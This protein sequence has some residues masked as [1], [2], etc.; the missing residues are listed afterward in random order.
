MEWT[1]GDTERLAI[2]CAKRGDASALH[3][4]YVRYADDVYR[5]V[6]SIVRDRHE[7][8]DVSQGVFA[9]LPTAID[10]YDDRD[11]PLAA[12]IVRLARGVALDHMRSRSEIPFEQVRIPDER[13]ERVGIERSRSLRTALERLPEE[14]R[15][16][17][18]RRHIGR[19]SPSEIAKSLGKSEGAV[20]G[21]YHSGRKALRR[22]LI[23]SGRVG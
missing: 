8:E 22:S 10:R 16:V 6:T 7:A 12:W 13:E 3:Y 15:Q 19:M 20:H 9:K 14:Q 2:A 11:V 23:S 18:I 4:L 21:L 5:Y 17:L 1:A